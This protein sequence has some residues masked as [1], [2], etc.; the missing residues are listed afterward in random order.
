[1]YVY[2]ICIMLSP[3]ITND[4]KK[5]SNGRSRVDRSPDE[6]Q[7]QWGRAV[8]LDAMSWQLEL[9]HVACGLSFGY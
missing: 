8:W 9:P 6:W 5:D 1:M 4:L 7:C 2:D 3:Q